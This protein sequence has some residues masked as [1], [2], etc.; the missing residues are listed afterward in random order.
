MDVAKV[1]SIR[2][3]ANN[4]LDKYG[5]IDVVACNAGYNLP[6]P[7]LE[8]TAET[9][10]YFSDVNCKGAFFVAM[11]AAHSLI[12]RN[13]KVSI[14]TISSQ[15]DIVGRRKGHGRAIDALVC[16]SVGYQQD[17]GRPAFPS[18]GWRGRAVRIAVRTFR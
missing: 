17:H 6:K 13:S 2:T 9:F 10:D 15:V 12:E 4:V 1:K 8:Y 16:R 18:T 14:I 5:R 11:L 7:A 3:R